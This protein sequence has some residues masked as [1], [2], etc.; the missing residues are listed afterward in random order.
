MERG[1]RSVVAI[2]AH[3]DDVELGCMGTLLKLR[4]RGARVTIVSIT[5]GDQ[6]AAHDPDADHAAVAEVRAAE[7][8]AAAER[9]G[10]EFVSL[11]GPDGYLF[12]ASALRDA[13]SAVIRRAGADLVFAPPPA[14]YQSDHIA[15]S[16]IAFHAVFTSALPQFPI[17]G[18]ALERTPVLYYYDAIMGLEF[19]PTLF[20]D[21]TDQ[22]EEKKALARLH[23]SQ[24]ANMKAIGGWD[25][26]EE[27]EIVG[28]YRGLQS[29]TRY[30][31]AFRPC[32]RWPRLRALREFPE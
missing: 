8:T 15:A 22:V 29:G 19:E 23:A 32:L 25:L 31:E 28:R 16:E 13:L 27:I 7:A 1:V 30:A 4:A 6:G 14:D 10:G 26:V 5:A 20:V 17:A 12:D 11:D 2:E 3:P 21:I 18:A 24:M 9:M